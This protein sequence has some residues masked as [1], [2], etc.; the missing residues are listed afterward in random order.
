MRNIIINNIG[1]KILALFLAIITWFYIVVELHKGTTDEMET[2]KGI[3]PYRMVSKQIPIRLDLV[4]TP[5]EGY[6]IDYDNIILKPP[7]CIMLGP[8]SVLNKI[9]EVKTQPI[10]ISDYT[11]VFTKDVNIVTPIKG[12]DIKEKFVTVTVPISKIAE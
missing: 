3:L 2:L 1:L 12:I 7:T 4:G 5:R 10:D 11:R 6:F 9:S 8:K